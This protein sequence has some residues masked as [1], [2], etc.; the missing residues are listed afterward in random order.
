LPPEPLTG[1]GWGSAPVGSNYDPCADLSTILVMIE[2]GTGSSPVQALMFHRGTY[3]GTG[4]SKAYGFTSLN[5][6]RSTD[7]TVVLNYKTPGACNACPP[8]AVTSVRYQW[9]GDHVAMLDP[10]PPS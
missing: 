5:A 7:D 4:T 9:Q 1:R 3:L 10:A 2:G 6:A 8:A